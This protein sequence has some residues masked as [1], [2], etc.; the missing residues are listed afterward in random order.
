MQIEIENLFFIKRKSFKFAARFNRFIA[1]YSVMTFNRK[2]DLTR[3]VI[4]NTSDFGSEECRFEPW[5]VN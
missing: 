4:G 1:G 3:S 5:R 2:Q